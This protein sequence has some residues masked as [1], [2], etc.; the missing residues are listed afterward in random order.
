MQNANDADPTG[1]KSPKRE[2]G[3]LQEGYPQ[4]FAGYA[5]GA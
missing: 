5:P 2:N 4:V 1:L 3:P